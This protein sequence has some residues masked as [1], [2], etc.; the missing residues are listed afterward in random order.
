MRAVGA[1]LGTSSA[2]EHGETAARRPDEDRHAE[3]P[4]LV[5]EQIPARE[6]QAVEIRQLLADDFSGEMVAGDE[7]H[8]RRFGLTL[9]QEVSMIL[10]ELRHLR[11]REPYEADAQAA[12]A[13]LV[14]PRGFLLVVHE[15][16]QHERDVAVDLFFARV[17]DLV[18]GAIGDGSQI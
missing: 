8:D 7:S 14:G 10:E 5:V 1:E 18:P 15:R 11:R 6:R 12:F 16:R 4:A 13:G 2:G 3:A 9:Y 17:R